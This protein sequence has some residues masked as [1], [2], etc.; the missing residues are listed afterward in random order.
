[1]LLFSKKMQRQEIGE[2]FQLLEAATVPQRPFSPNRPRITMFGMVAGLAL[3]V[4]L[5]GLLEYRDNGLKTD[6]QV[7]ALL[8]L[9]VLAVVPV[10]QSEDERRRARLRNVVTH[11]GLGMTVAGCLAVLAYTFVR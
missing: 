1:M 9:P 6:K 10:M 7:V 5:V 4:A 2:Q 8:G 3:G 11:L